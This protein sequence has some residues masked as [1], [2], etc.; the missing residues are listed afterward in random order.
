MLQKFSRMF[1]IIYKLIYKN[2]STYIQ[3]S[4]NV[5]TYIHEPLKGTTDGKDYTYGVEGRFLGVSL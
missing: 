3:F 5:S 4:R 1:Q 2:V